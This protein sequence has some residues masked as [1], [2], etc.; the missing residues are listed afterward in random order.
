MQICPVCGTQNRLTAHFC[1]HCGNYLAAGAKVLAPGT[2]LYNRYIIV[3]ML[4]QGGM[5]VIYLAQDTHLGNRICVVK[6]MMPQAGDQ[7]ARQQAVQWFEREAILLSRLQHPNIPRVTDHFA[8]SG[9]YYLVM[10]YVEGENLEEIL[11]REGRPWLDESRVVNWAAQI[12][13]VLAYLHE[14]NPPI[15]FRDMKP[16]N[17][18]LQRDGRI[19]LIDFGI[20]RHFAPSPSGTAVG[21]PGYAPPEQYFGRAEPRSDLYA[22]G[23]TLHHLLSGR[24][25]DPYI[26]FALLRT[27]NPN[28]TSELE[29]IVAKALSQNPQD[30]QQSAREFRRALENLGGIFKFQVDFVHPILDKNDNPLAQFMIKIT[31]KDGT[32]QTPAQTHFCLLLDV[33]GSMR[34]GAND[35]DLSGQKYWP[36]LQATQYLVSALPVH[37]LI[38]IL[39]FA[40]RSD[41]IIAAK[42]VDECKS[43][44]IGGRDGLIDASPVA[45]SPGRYTNLNAALSKAFEITRQLQRPN[46]VHRLV[47]LTDGQIH[48]IESC[49]PL[50]DQIR[51]SSAE[52]YAYGFGTDWQV[53]PLKTMLTGCRGGSFKPVSTSPSVSTFDIT[54]TF[55]RI[56]QASQNIVATN[57]SLEVAFSPQVKPGDAFRYSPVARLLGSNVYANNVFRTGIEAL[58]LG[59][60]YT[61][62]FEVRLQPSNES[63]QQI[64]TALL[65]YNHQGN[66][67]AQSQTILVERD[68]DPKRFR[69]KDDEVEEVFTFLEMLR[70]ADPQKQLQALIARLDIATRKGYDPEHLNALKNAITV[71]Q[72]GGRI[73]DLPLKDQLWV[74]S[75]P[76][77]KSVKLGP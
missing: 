45:Q 77:G 26:P 74:R 21:T 53:E 4:K 36:L 15:I 55:S 20:A 27:L 64:G 2:R 40:E 7:Q 73:E 76:R 46:L 72:S 25:P 12:C 52:I 22:L 10:D 41:L 35:V 70:N 19:K 31:T 39:V 66:D 69:L 37:S 6:E 33:S 44:N 5:S 8:E 59:Q 3:R 1:S 29:A 38:S 50:F 71:L 28:I 56:A 34:V 30:R 68:T 16:A 13:D 9:R 42:L 61:W 58:E 63:V 62:C 75:D 32:V 24:A 11:R 48:D 18:M 54:S 67:V 60:E 47:L 49:S 57:A 51:A 14:Q 65:R 43:L 23:A 17:V